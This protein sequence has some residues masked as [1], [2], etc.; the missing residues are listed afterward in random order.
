[1]NAK[2]KEA[3]KRLH[4]AFEDFVDVM[5]D[6]DATTAEPTETKK[7]RGGTA[8]T[9][10]APAKEKKATPGKKSKSEDVDDEKGV[11]GYSMSDLEEMGYNGMKALAKQLGFVA[12]GDRDAIANMIMTQTAPEAD[13]EDEAEAP[14]PKKG[15]S[16]PAKKSP[17]PLGKKSA[18][19]PEPEDDEDEDDD[20]S[21]DDGVEA[22]VISAT[23]EMSDEDLLDFLL[24]SG[25]KAK[26]KRQALIA[27]VVKG[28]RDGKI[29]LEDDGEDDT[30]DEDDSEEGDSD[31][32]FDVNDPKNPDMTEERAAG[33]KALAADYKAQFKAGDITREDIIEYINDYNGTKDKMT[34]V[35][36]KDLLSK[37]IDIACLFVDDDGEMPDD[38][39]PEAYTVNGNPYCCG[40]ELRYDEDGEQY[41]CESCGKE[42][43]ADDEE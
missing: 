41:I 7:T 10:T 20:D 2:Q 13:D 26:G 43:P 4:G 18:P 6:D 1:M 23:E 30:D 32:D 40:H 36:D 35:S 12:K 5:V 19:E 31:S 21:E 28:V 15:K 3:L 42:Y 8:K 27:A 39:E 33:I 38:D 17:R 16:A 14:A 29:E 25:I 34:K 24:E 37:F 9:E 22:L 11:N